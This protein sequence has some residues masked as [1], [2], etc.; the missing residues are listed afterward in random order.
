MKGRGIKGEGLVN[1]LGIYI[2]RPLPQ[3]IDYDQ[4]EVLGRQLPKRCW[5]FNRTKSDFKEV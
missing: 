4:R 2:D 1:N 5:L 3:M